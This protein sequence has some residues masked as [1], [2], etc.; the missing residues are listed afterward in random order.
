MRLGRRRRW[1]SWSSVS[2]CN[3]CI[4]IGISGTYTTPKLMRAQTAILFL[5]ERVKFH[6]TAMGSNVQTMSANTETAVQYCQWQ[7]ETYGM[8]NIHVWR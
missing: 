4:M 8:V 3:D 2:Y 6:T 1:L 5:R 7:V